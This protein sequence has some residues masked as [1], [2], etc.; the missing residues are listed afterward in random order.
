MKNLFSGNSTFT[1]WLELLLFYFIL[2]IIKTSPF[3]KM[4]FFFIRNQKWYK[5]FTIF[6]YHVLTCYFHRGWN[7][8]WSFYLR[9]MWGGEG[10]YVFFRSHA[11]SRSH[12]VAEK[13]KK[14]VQRCPPT[15]VL[16]ESKVWTRKKVG[17]HNYDL[18]KKDNYFSISTFRIFGIKSWFPIDGLINLF[19]SSK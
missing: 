11:R 13:G 9:I 7:V 3:S 4:L 15:M 18:V 1:K 19:Y 12:A 5:K 2:L 16:V 10:F 17:L 6:T 8:V 14:I